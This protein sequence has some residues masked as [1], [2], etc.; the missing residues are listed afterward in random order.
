MAGVLAEAWDSAMIVL[1][2]I[3]AGFV[4]VLAGWLIYGVMLLAEE[5]S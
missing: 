4:L 2:V 1:K 5:R 3:L